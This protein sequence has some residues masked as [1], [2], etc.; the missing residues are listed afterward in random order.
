MACRHPCWTAISRWNDVA[1]RRDSLASGR[2]PDRLVLSQSARRKLLK[3]KAEK[4]ALVAQLSVRC[5]TLH[6]LC[7]QFDGKVP[8]LDYWV[9]QHPQS[10]ISMSC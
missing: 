4:T 2:T 1:C 9:V 10:D 5:I 8:L 6:D 7:R 3:N